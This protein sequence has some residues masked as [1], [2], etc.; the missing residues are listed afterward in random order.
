MQ[1]YLISF[2]QQNLF[3]SAVN[4]A[5]FYRYFVKQTNSVKLLSQKL[6]E[7]ET[8]TKNILIIAHSWFSIV[9]ANKSSNVLVLTVTSKLLCSVQYVCILCV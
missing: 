2:K 4:S 6:R 1:S 3:S 8:Q 5:G 7:R 9:L